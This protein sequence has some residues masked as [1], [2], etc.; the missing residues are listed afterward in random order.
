MASL[1]AVGRR[2]NE[3]QLARKRPSAEQTARRLIILRHVVVYALAWPSREV[4]REKLRRRNPADRNTVEREG[5]GIRDETW[6]YMRCLGLLN[7]MSPWERTFSKSTMVTMTRQQQIDASWKMEAVQVLMW[8][9]GFLGELPAYGTQADQTLLTALPV[10]GVR[11]FLDSARLRHSIEIHQARETA[12]LW[13]RRSRARQLL[14]DGLDLFPD[15]KLNAA[16]Y[17]TYRASIRNGTQGGR[18]ESGAQGDLAVNGKLYRDLTLEEWA[19]VHSISVER[20]HALNW[21][22][23]RAPGNRWDETPTTP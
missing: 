21:L 12:E 3:G 22:C 13:C 9:L 16:G 15:A 4:M 10:E 23:G 17:N 18:I 11:S 20:L 1:N 8:A 5:E 14:E 2:P 7:D 6:G 19:E